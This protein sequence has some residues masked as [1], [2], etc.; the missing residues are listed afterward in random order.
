MNKTTTKKGDWVVFNGFD[1]YF[2]FTII[3]QH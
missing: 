3:D 1:D 2:V